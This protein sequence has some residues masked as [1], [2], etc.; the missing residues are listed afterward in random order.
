M[1]TQSST[2]KKYLLPATLSLTGIFIG[3]YTNLATDD[4]PE[5]WAYPM[6][7]LLVL[8]GFWAAFVQFKRDEAE[9]AQAAKQVDNIEDHAVKTYEIVRLFENVNILPDEKVDVS[10]LPD[11]QPHFTGRKA[12]LHLLDKGWKNPKTNIVQ[13][14][15]P[16]GTGK[17]M[18]VTYW[19]HHHLPRSPAAKP[20]AIYA[21]SF[22]SQGSDEGRQASSDL[23][24]EKPRVFRRRGGC[25]PTPANAVARSPNAAAGTLPAH[26]RRHRAAAIPARHPG[27]TGRKTQGPRAGRPAARTEFR[28]A[29]AVHPDHPRCRDGTGRHR[30]AAAPPPTPRKF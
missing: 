19:L 29:R 26:P 27:R 25:P 14:I 15:A 30:R 13:F 17:T 3:L 5:W 18:L 20:A 9:K 10:H 6:L 1:P 23:F 7:G 16:G 22:Y 2:F 28:A 21:W 24:F 4:K 12:E 8:A 11:L